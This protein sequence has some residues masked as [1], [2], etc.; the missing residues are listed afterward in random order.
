MLHLAPAARLLGQGYRL[1][2]VDLAQNQLRDAAV[3]ALLEAVAGATV[4]DLRLGQNPFGETA[5][6]RLAALCG[7]GGFPELRSPRPTVP[8]P[9]LKL[10]IPKAEDPKA[11][12]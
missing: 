5:L 1:A 6:L 4:R 7:R 12:L 2:V 11:Y 8:P 3:A 9:V 10:N